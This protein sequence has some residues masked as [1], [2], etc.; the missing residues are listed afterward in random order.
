L[1]AVPRPASAA[2]REA[3]RQFRGGEATNRR[4]VAC[5]IKVMIPLQ[6]ATVAALAA[7]VSGPSR[8]RLTLTFDGRSVRA[9]GGAGSG[10]KE[11]RGLGENGRGSV[12]CMLQGKLA[13]KN[14]VV[15]CGL[16][17][18]VKAMR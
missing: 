1:D 2:E 4:G 6:P 13:P 7:P 16:V 18:Q 11:Q 10:S 5:A 3:H 8:I 9:G 12:F 15:E 14:E 17:G